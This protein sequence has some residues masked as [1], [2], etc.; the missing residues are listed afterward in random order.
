MASL[1]AAR[2]LALGLPE[3]TEQPYHGFPSF[4]VGGKI[5]ANLPDHDHM[6]L[7][8]SEEEI[9][10]AVASFEGCEE[11]WWGKKLSALRIT[12]SLLDEGDLGGLLVAAWRR[13]ASKTLQASFDAGEV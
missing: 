4:R 12:L 6:H 13:R 1:D 7:M 5:F 11:Q 10:E 8:L 9:R 3:A 2:S